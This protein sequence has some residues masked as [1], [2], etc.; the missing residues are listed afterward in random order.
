MSESLSIWRGNRQCGQSFQLRT[1]PICGREAQHLVG[2][3]YSQIY[4]CIYIHY[5]EN[6]EVEAVHVRSGYRR[7]LQPLSHPP[8]TD[9]WS[10]WTP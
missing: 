2:L 9:E 7:T 3:R 8:Q 1:C 6:S 10:E 4:L 5:D